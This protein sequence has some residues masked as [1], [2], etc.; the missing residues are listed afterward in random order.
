MKPHKIG[1]RNF[2]YIYKVK[3]FRNIYKH[4]DDYNNPFL[5]LL[6]VDFSNFYNQ[7]FLL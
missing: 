7:Y 2:P 5:N 6:N 4:L 3:V 1:Y